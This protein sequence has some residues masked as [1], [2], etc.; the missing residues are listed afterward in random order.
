METPSSVETNLEIN[1]AKNNNKLEDDN[2]DIQEEIS[3]DKEIADQD[4]TPEAQEA[5]I[6]KDLSLLK[7]LI[8]L[9]YFGP[10]L[11]QELAE[12]YA[13]YNGQ[14]LRKR[15]NVPVKEFLKGHK[16]LFKFILKH[17]V[18]EEDESKKKQT[19]ELVSL[20][21]DHPIVKEEL[22]D[23]PVTTNSSPNYNFMSNKVSS[24]H[25]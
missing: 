20:K 6:K 21:M 15:T 23:P 3:D 1:I 16:A 12:L 19:L 24:T 7:E 18:N 8:I 9:L 13:Q 4:L 14:N 10:L 17:Q 5:R 22:A 25:N 11:P 2:D